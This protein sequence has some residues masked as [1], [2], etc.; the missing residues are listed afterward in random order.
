MKKTILTLANTA[1]FVE[2]EPGFIASIF[3]IIIFIV[4]LTKQLTCA[5]SLLNRHEKSKQLEQLRPL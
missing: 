1:I 5:W 4:L 3:I 2:V